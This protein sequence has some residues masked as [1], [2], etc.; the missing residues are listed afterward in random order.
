MVTQAEEN[1]L[2]MATLRFTEVLNTLGPLI[3]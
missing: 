3:F 2:I 1:M